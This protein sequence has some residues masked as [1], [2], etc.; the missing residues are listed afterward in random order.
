MRAANLLKKQYLT[1][2][3]KLKL[4]GFLLAVT[5]LCL[6]PIL[7]NRKQVNPARK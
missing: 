3:T 1:K 2:T 6:I 4:G 7:H 5:Y